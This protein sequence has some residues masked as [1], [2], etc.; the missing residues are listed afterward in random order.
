[1]RIPMVGCDGLSFFLARA[2]TGKSLSSLN[3]SKNFQPRVPFLWTRYN[4]SPFHPLP[5]LQMGAIFTAGNMLYYCGSDSAS[6]HVRNTR[7]VYNTVTNTWSDLTV[8]DGALN[9][10]GHSNGFTT[11][12]TYTGGGFY[13]GTGSPGDSSSLDVQGMLV[14]DGSDK[15]SPM[16]LNQT[17][18][19]PNSDAGIMLYIPLSTG[20]ILIAFESRYRH[21]KRCVLRQ[22][23]LRN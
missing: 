5:D 14:F 17:S 20:A 13:L 1:M 3:L 23:L 7:I 4:P 19:I 12:D 18:N 10:A 11:T 15:S 2:P 8:S 16:W 6:P 22:L 21:A 9:I